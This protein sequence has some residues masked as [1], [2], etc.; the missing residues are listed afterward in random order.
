LRIG[1]N[2]AEQ[3]VEELTA[4]LNDALGERDQARFE[5]RNAV[6]AA[7]K[8]RDEV[9][10]SRQQREASNDME[11]RLRSI[12]AENIRELASVR[13]ERDTAAHNLLRLERDLNSCREDVVAVKSQLTEISNERDDL[14]NENQNVVGRYMDAERRAEEHWKRVMEGIAEIERLRLTVNE[15]DSPLPH[16][17][18]PKTTP[19]PTKPTPK[20]KST[21]KQ[22]HKPAASTSSVQPIRPPRLSRNPNPIY[23]APLSP[24]S[25][26][27]PPT[28]PM[29]PKPDRKRK[30]GASEADEANKQQ[31]KKRRRK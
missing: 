18:T 25:P 6:V 8:A 15:P 5:A 31:E 7:Q 1:L 19:K 2:N 27:P 28:I 20:S 30:R 16:I 17:P 11:R 23:T 13:E 3:E 10:E 14:V 21:S 22:K 4:Q 26:T 29:A 9:V 24:G 12:S